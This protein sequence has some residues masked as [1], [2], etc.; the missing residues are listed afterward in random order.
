MKQQKQQ[1][2]QFEILLFSSKSYTNMLTSRKRLA[3]LDLPTA[4]ITYAVNLT[5]LS[6]QLHIYA[7]KSMAKC[8][9][10]N[11]VVTI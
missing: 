9:H 3:S 10:L 1:F 7:R 4:V 8:A 2:Y 5:A 6:V 11:T